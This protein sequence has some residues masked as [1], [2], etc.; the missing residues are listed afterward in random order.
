M[1]LA[2]KV[3]M[4]NYRDFVDVILLY[5]SLTLPPTQYVYGLPNVTLQLTL[6]NTAD[7]WHNLFLLWHRGSAVL[8][9]CNVGPYFIWSVS[10]ATSQ[11]VLYDVR[12]LG[13]RGFSIPP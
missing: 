5:T 1:R 6:L 10:L 8:N 13:D 7:V 2:L 3:V 11:T 9:D 12:H 4:Q